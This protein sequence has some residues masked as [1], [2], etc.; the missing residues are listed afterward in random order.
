MVVLPLSLFH[1]FVFSILMIPPLGAQS[2]TNTLSYLRPFLVSSRFFFA[3]NILGENCL[4]RS[5]CK[6]PPFLCLSGEQF[7]ALPLPGIFFPKIFTGCYPVSLKRLPAEFL[8][9][10]I[11]FLSTK[12]IFSH[13]IPLW[14]LCTT[15]N[16]VPRWNTFFFCRQV[17][18]FKINF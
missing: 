18:R 2:V 9:L 3:V 12:L 5:P 13:T 4:D 6:D 17:I 10:F 8:F 7:R 15:Y 16:D 14:H 11:K 1:F